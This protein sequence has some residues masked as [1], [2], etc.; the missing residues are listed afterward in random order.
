MSELDNTPRS[1]ARVD[2]LRGHVALLDAVRA[3]AVADQP[4]R[5]SFAEPGLGVVAALVGDAAEE[6]DRL[7]A[8]RVGAVFAE[9]GA[10]DV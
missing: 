3:T 7:E 6:L 5:V 1:R 8:R 4:D 2:R 10:V 9:R